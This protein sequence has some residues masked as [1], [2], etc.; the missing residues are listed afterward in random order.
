VLGWALGLGLESGFERL[1]KRDSSTLELPG[2]QE[3]L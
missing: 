2:V 3:G 1:L